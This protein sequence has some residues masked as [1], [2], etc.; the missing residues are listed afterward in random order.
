VANPEEA[1]EL[2]LTGA[3]ACVCVRVAHGPMREL[4]IG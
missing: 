4:A 2:L 3:S 1:A